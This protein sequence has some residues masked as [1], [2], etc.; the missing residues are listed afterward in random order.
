[1]LIIE[2]RDERVF[3]VFYKK[4]RLLNSVRQHLFLL[5]ASNISKIKE[6]H[7]K[8]EQLYPN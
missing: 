4:Y 2:V 7:E 6:I 5:M 1:M 3:P 8:F